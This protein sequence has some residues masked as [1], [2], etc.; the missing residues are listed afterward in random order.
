[1]KYPVLIALS[2]LLPLVDALTAPA[3]QGPD[4]LWEITTKVEMSGMPFAPRP[5]TSRVCLQKGKQ[6]EGVIPKDQNCRME[7][8]RRTGNRT[9]FHLVCE[10]KDKMTGDVDITSTSD[11]YQGSMRMQGTMEGRQ[12]NMTNQY[13]GR[14]VGSCTWEDPVAKNRAG[15]QFAA[16]PCRDAVENLNWLVFKDPAMASL[17][18]DYRGQ[19]F[20][21]VRQVAKEMRD[22]AEFDRRVRARSDMYQMLEFAG[23]NPNQ[24]RADACRNGVTSRNWTFVAN[25]CDAE[26]RE[27]ALQQCTGRDPSAELVFEYAPICRRYPR[28]A[29]RGGEVRPPAEFG[30]PSGKRTGGAE[31]VVSEPAA[32]KEASPGEPGGALDKAKQGLQK[33]KGLF[34]R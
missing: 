26:A 24:V 5:Q 23:E 14:R 34:G 15:T 32:P 28:S 13:S 27:I 29:L 7:N 11:N 20:D 19:F 22:P 6:E 33:L 16:A 30:S 18:N 4:D 21:R 31:Q 25:Y 17:C 12:V 3:A 1:M 8:L 2:A 9:T 10:G